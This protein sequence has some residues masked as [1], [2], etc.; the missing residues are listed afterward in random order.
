MAPL[1]PPPGPGPPP[2][3]LSPKP[4]RFGV[5]VVG[6][7][8][9]FVGELGSVVVVSDDVVGVVVVVDGGVVGV[10]G[11]DGGGVGV[12]EAGFGPMNSTGPKF[13]FGLLAR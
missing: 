5:D 8:W 11:V 2:P 7:P 10:V 1:A 3:G 9:E 6:L 12:T 13:S 4:G